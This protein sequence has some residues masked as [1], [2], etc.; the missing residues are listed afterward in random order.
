MFV[1]HLPNLDKPNL[2]LPNLDKPNL[3]LPNLDKPN[4]HLPNLTHRCTQ[5]E[6]P[7]EGVPDIFA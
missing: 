7:G 2:H 6:N 4:L 1:G 5:V 3:H